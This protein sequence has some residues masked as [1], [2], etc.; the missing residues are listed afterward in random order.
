VNHLLIISL[1]RSGGKLLRMLL[2]GHTRLNVFP[3]EHWNRPVKASYPAHRI[4][5]F[6]RMSVDEK[7]ATAGARF[8]ERKIRRLHPDAL[9]TAVMRAWMADA[10]KATTLPAMYDSLGHRYFEAIGR[11]FT[12]QVVNHCGGLCRLTPTQIDAVFGP[13]THLITIRDPRAVFVSMQ[14][15]RYKKFTFKRIRMGKVS[16]SDTERHIARMEVVDGASGYLRGFCDDY[17]NMVAQHAGR[18]EIIRVRFEDLVT[19]PEATMRQVCGRLGFPWEPALLAPTQ[20]GVPRS[21]NSSYGR[22]GDGIHAQAAA[23]WQRRIAPAVCTY[24]EEALADEMRV[25]GYAPVI[26]SSQPVA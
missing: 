21:A 7:L 13:G 8:V 23:D 19:S 6:E 25:F 15:L 14:A 26:R 16:E 4:E 20:F 11:D 9:A 24:I 2:D 3:F 17:R 22:Q 12:D 18:K 5:A 1:S 10:A